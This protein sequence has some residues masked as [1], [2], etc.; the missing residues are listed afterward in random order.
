M[1]VDGCR[2]RRGLVFVETIALRSTVANPDLQGEHQV[3]LIPF[4]SESDSWA[5]LEPESLVDCYMG[6]LGKRIRLQA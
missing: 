5:R 2:T 3:P 1:L 4:Y 6:M